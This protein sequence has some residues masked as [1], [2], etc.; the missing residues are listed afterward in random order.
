MM[1][2]IFLLFL[3]LAMLP[4]P[5]H[6]WWNADWSYRKKITLN[7]GAIGAATKEAVAPALIAVRLSTGNFPF[8][9]AKPDG[10]D[11]RFIAGDDR[12]PLRF[13]IERFDAVNELA[14]VW[15][16]V[17]RVSGGTTGESIWM[18]Y[19]NQRAVSAEDA[20]GSFDTPQLLALRLSETA[21][22]PRDATAYGHH[23]S[24]SDARLGVN[25]PLAG[26]A[27]FDGKA[28][29][30][31]PA[32]PSLRAPAKE[33][34]TLTAWV[35]I[36]EA[37]GAATVVSFGEGGRGL[38]LALQD[39]RPLARLAV[40]AKPA[41]AAAAAALASGSW[42]HL[43]AVLGNGRLT[44]YVNGQEA[45]ATAAAATELAGEV[46]IGAGLR[47]EIDEVTLAAVA[48]SAD[49]I[50]LAYASQGPNATLLSWGEGEQL[51]GGGHSHMGILVD[52]LTIDAWVVIVICAVMLVVA[53]WV[54]IV[55]T[56]QIART[57]RANQRFLE[58]FTQLGGDL[59]RLESEGARYADSALF[60]LYQTGIVELKR[61]VALG[62]SVGAAR[63]DIDLSA[64][65]LG[66]IRSS[67]DGTLVRENHRLNS[68]VVLLSIAI[69]GGPFLGL[70]GTVIGVMITFAAVAAAGD[71]NINAI[72]PGIAAALLATVAGLAVA[73][74]AL[75][76]YNW[77]VTRIKKVNAD[78][79][80]FVEE[81]MAKLA[82]NYSR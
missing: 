65:T 75:F 39:G 5:A 2:R 71:V 14:V 1:R 76:G 21:G 66:A 51:A 9:D 3:L 31:I 68:Q 4:L 63:A 22:S 35:R 37:A 26:A 45:A 70:L 43:A 69:S 16:Q 73:I 19:G 44:L 17:P 20:R 13:H 40:A 78:M 58:A 67:V 29:I 82:E 11:L 12:T 41:E 30:L 34:A 36:A 49:A 48:R 80:V 77:L 50:R 55:K 79:Q 64:N 54:M 60:R 23:A 72:A 33:G 24:Q 62:A 47:G 57:D 18:Y 56:I 27:A 25:G 28:R 53:I 74:P 38:S 59:T 6:A 46:V 10:S 15:V 7:T 81:L 32:A 42:T 8:L 52:A 61:R